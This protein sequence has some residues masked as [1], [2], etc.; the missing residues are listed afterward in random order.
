VFHSADAQASG[1]EDVPGTKNRGVDSINL[2][3]REVV[4]AHTNNV[5]VD[6]LPLK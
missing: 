5:Q 6:V 3:I 2:G 4:D 1:P